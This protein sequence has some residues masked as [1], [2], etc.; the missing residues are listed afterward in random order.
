MVF[1]N[2]KLFQTKK[3][4]TLDEIVDRGVPSN[5]FEETPYTFT[6]KWG[7]LETFLKKEVMSSNGRTPLEYG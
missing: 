6:L 4:P 5:I 3:S 1:F 2:T 7:K